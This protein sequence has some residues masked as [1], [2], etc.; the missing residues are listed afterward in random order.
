MHSSYIT[1]FLER[2]YQ[3]IPPIYKVEEKIDPLQKLSPAVILNI[4]LRFN[5]STL[6]NC[7]LVNKDWK[8][9]GYIFLN[10][11]REFLYEKVVFSPDDWEVYLEENSLKHEEKL[12][13]FQSLPPNLAEIACPIYPGKMLIQ[14]HL[15]TYFPRNLTISSYIELLEI[16]FGVTK[17]YDFIWKEIIPKFGSI[18]VQSYGW[19]AMSRQVLSSNY[20]KD[21]KLHK[22]SMDALKNNI[23]RV[24]SIL[25]AIVAI[26]THRFKSK[27]KLFNNHFAFCSES[28]HDYQ[29]VVR[30]GY[31]GLYVSLGFIVS[32]NNVG[33]APIHDLLKD[34]SIN[35][36]FIFFITAKR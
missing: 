34:K 29:A 27:I 13:A 14:T 18:S 7:C 4:F 11:K 23:F 22:P 32:Q 25:E 16:K 9:L 28:I 20:G 3:T 10:K 12:K 31:F 15:I 36:N 17:G 1:N 35:Q 6:N 21:F 2:I 24:P 19:K 26:S 33:I 30:Y 5:C 8:S